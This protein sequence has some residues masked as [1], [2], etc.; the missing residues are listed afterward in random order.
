MSGEWRHIKPTSK[1]QVVTT[2]RGNVYF[3]GRFITEHLFP[4]VSLN[5]QKKVKSDLQSKILPGESIYYRENGEETVESDKEV[6]YLKICTSLTD[7]TEY[8][9]PIWILCDVKKD[10]EALYKWYPIRVGD[11]VDASP[12]LFLMDGSVLVTSTKIKMILPFLSEDQQEECVRNL[13]GC[14]EKDKCEFFKG[15]KLTGEDDPEADFLQIR[16][17]LI[18]V[19]KRA[20]MWIQCSRSK[21]AGCKWFANR[22][23]G[24][25]NLKEK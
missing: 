14:I 3:S 1:P 11:F 8:R 12:H 23:G 10:P 9:N 22:I 24:H 20:P 7:K 19:K 17:T 6:R 18:D 15:K 21:S 5:Q 2:I 25:M 4:K 16:T 13:A